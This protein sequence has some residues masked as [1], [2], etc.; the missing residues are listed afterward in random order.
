[1]S[2]FDDYDFDLDRDFNSQR[3]LDLDDELDMY[4]YDP[5]VRRRRPEGSRPSGARRPAGSRPAASRSSQPRQGAPRRRPE[6]SRPQQRRPEGSRPSGSRSAGSRSG[7]GRPSVT[8]PDG[9]RASSRAAADRRNSRPSNS[10]PAG[11]KKTSKAAQKKKN[12]RTIIIIEIVILLILAIVIYFWSKF[13]KVNW[14]NI[15]MEQVKSNELDAA[16]EEVLSN[17]KTIALFGVDNRSNGKLDSGNS[18]AIILVSINN[19][20]KDVKMLSVQRDTY[21]QVEKDLYRKC[22]YAYNHGG[23]EQALEMLNTNLDIKIDGYVAVDFYA[24]ATI[25]DCLDGL[26]LEITQKMIT[27]N[28]PET[29]Q[30]ALAGYIAEVENIL[31]YYPNEEEGWK[32]SD[33]YFDSPGT[34][35]LNGAQVVG[36]CRNRYAVNNDYGRAENQRMV[37]KMIVEKAKHASPSQLNDIA[38]KVF[39]KIAT[40]LSFSQCVGMATD[41]GKYNMAES[42]GFPFALKTKTVSKKTGSVVVPCTLT[43]NVAQLHKFLYDQDDYDP[44][45][46]VVDVISE[47]IKSETGLSESSA[48]ITQATDGSGQ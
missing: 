30:N 2:N 13:G 32:Y 9:G 47:H 45:D 16:T 33:C 34:Y 44:T 21:L 48:E 42:S 38:D 11:R 8:R 20:T 24:L 3:G 17:Y 19:D 27:T 35:H 29:G 37:I 6:G 18:D 15:N 5:D 28:N 31:N 10:R 43:S 22:N 40:S 7:N 14:D 46:D 36:F 25:V 41:V 26:D 39:P 1:M 12:R 23:V 4:D